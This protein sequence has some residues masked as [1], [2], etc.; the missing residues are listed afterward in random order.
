MYFFQYKPSCP[1]TGNCMFNC[2][3]H[4]FN[5]VVLQELSHRHDLKFLTDNL[6]NMHGIVSRRS[7]NERS[8]ESNS[9]FQYSYEMCFFKLQ[10]TRSW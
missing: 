5:Y 1:G 3:C 10:R 4:A 9:Y 8:K 2:T 7:S 6:C